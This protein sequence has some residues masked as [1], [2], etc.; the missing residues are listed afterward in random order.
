MNICEIEEDELLDI[1]FSENPDKYF[2]YYHEIMNSNLSILRIY[3]SIC[4]SNNLKKKIKARINNNYY[5]DCVFHRAD[6]LPLRIVEEKKYWGCYGCGYSGSI[7]TLISKFYGISIEES[8]EL[9]HSYLTNKTDELNEKQINILKE[10]FRYYNS[11]DIDEI[12]KE[13][14]RKTEFLDKR[15]RKYIKDNNIY[16]NEEEKISNRLCCSKKYVKK[17]ISKSSSF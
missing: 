7:I 15:I 9:L 2:K 16:L 10:M 4:E 6:D 5:C 8:L 11:S 3:Y 1:N 12:I 17:I 13:S 14:R